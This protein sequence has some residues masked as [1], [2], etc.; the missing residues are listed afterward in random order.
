MATRLGQVYFTLKEAPHRIEISE[1]S[2]FD[3]DQR[4]PSDL[5]HVYGVNPISIGDLQVCDTDIAESDYGEI[6]I[7]QGEL[8]AG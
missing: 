4:E 8:I 5:G 2:P 7:L 1:G 6:E 3:A